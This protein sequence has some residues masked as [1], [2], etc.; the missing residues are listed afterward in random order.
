MHQTSRFSAF[1]RIKTIKKRTKYKS[2][3]V[4]I[5]LCAS[6]SLSVSLSLS[7][8]VSSSPDL[9]N[10]LG[11]GF[12]LLAVGDDGGRL[13][14]HYDTLTSAQHVQSHGLQSHAHLYMWKPRGKP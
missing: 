7:L 1:E 2:K 3:E 5:C 14:A 10:A 11:D 4:S 9:R 6:L 13:F 12:G 8:H